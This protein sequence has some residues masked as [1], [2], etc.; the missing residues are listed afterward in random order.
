[1]ISFWDPALAGYAMNKLAVM[2]LEGKEPTD[3]MSLELPG[4]EKVSLDGKVIR[5]QA[6]VDVT[7]DNAKD[8]PF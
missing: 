8:Y 1:M 4:Y 3:G 7:K 2:L 6:W 5:G